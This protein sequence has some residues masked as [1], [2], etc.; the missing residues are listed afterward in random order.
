MQIGRSRIT[1]VAVALSA[2]VFAA[3]ALSPSPGNVLVVDDDGSAPFAT[4]QTAVD[5]A[6]DG[7]VVL[8]RSG[9]YARVEIRGKALVVVGDLGAAVQVQGGIRVVDLAAN[10]TVVLA[11]LRSTGA[12]SSGWEFSPGLDLSNDAGSVRVEACVVA[13][14]ESGSAHGVRARACADVA[15]IGCDVRGGAASGLNQR[16]GSDGIAASQSSVVTAHGCVVRGGNGQPGSCALGIGHDGGDGGDVNGAF[17]FSSGS[18]FTGGSGGNMGY[19][20]SFSCPGAGWGG[21]GLL[22]HGATV[23]LLDSVA[24]GGLPGLCNGSSCGFS[25]CDN[26]YFGSD[27]SGG[28]FSDL[29]GDARSVSTTS[30]GHA[31]ATTTITLG[32]AP[33]DQVTLLIANATAPA[34]FVPGWNGMLL[35]PRPRIGGATRVVQA[36]AIPASGVL[37]VGFVLPAPAQPGIARTFFVQALFRDPLGRLYLSGARSLTVLP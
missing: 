32:G 16:I 5:A 36:G 10:E 33:G 31:G 35:V 12:T 13:G 1:S 14:A 19:G 11:H 20:S 7:D 2:L 6:Q 29:V 17:L 22:A 27:R 18:S 25:C 24:T 4:I 8:V 28:T 15:L 30:P 34:E 9:T 26:G 21:D 23:R 3:P 37:G